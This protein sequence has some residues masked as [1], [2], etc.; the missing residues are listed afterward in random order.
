MQHEPVPLFK[1]G[2]SG[3]IAGNQGSEVPKQL[4]QVKDF[5]SV[6]P[7]EPSMVS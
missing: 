6:N 5:E 1:Q 4:T 2:D 3:T 7:S